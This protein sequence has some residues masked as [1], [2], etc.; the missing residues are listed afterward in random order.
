MPRMLIR[1]AA[2]GLSALAGIV[3]RRPQL[4]GILAA[5]QIGEIRLC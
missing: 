4:R 2:I 3:Y 1:G 5:L